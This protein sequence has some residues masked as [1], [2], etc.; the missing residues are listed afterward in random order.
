MVLLIPMDPKA[1]TRNSPMT[2]TAPPPTPQEAFSSHTF[3]L[4]LEA[5]ARPGTLQR[6]PEP[7]ATPPALPDATLP[8]P[9]AVAACLTLVDQ[10]TG[11]AHAHSGAWIAPDLPLSRWMALRTNARLATP[12]LA[13]Y[14]ILHDI[15]SAPLLT[16]LKQGSLTFPERS[17]TAFLCVAELSSAGATWRLRGP[18]INGTI[19]VGLS[20]LPATLLPAILATRAHFPLGIDLLCVDRSG[21]CLGLPR[22]TLIDEV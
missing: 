2:Q 16:E 19:T 13:D 10:E 20:G 7:L 21:L 22:T 9:Y 1:P 4:L 6:L 17:A 18:G 3:R 12:S 11:L 8:N 15:P 14:V 5:L